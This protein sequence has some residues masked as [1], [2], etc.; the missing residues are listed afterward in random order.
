MVAFVDSVLVPLTNVEGLFRNGMSKGN[1]MGAGLTSRMLSLFGALYAASLTAG[2]QYHNPADP[3]RP[4]V[5]T[6]PRA[7][8]GQR[9]SDPIIQSE[10]SRGEGMGGGSSRSGY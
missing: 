2:C 7:A 1:G 10:G 3:R 6:D 9:M 5:S 4:T 8:R